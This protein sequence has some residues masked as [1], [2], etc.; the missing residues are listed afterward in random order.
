MNPAATS[1]AVI[2]TPDTNFASIPDFPFAPHYIELQTAPSGLR[3]HY[4]DEG[5]RN[6]PIA[7]L[8]HGMPTWSYLYRH[9]IAPVVAAGYR[10]IA[11]D[12]IG[13]GRSDKPVLE[14][15]HTF[16]LH[17]VMLL[18]LIERLDLKNILLV[19]NAVYSFGQQLSN[20]IPIASFKEDPDDQEFTYLI[21]H[22]E[23][24]A[25]FDDVREYNKHK[26]QL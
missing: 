1:N 3:M 24:C 10:V 25:S 15:T 4:V 16:D 21:P 7:L 20:G 2:R 9:M 5:P 13:F 19:D 26:F 12:L 6:A 14:A 18:A 17:R 8:L 22:L 11:P 23:A